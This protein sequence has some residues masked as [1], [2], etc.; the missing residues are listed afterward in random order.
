M[1]AKGRLAFTPEVASWLAGGE[2]PIVVT[3][4]GGWLG[5]AVLEMVCGALGG[6]FAGRVFAFASRR[7]EILL[8][9]GGRIV[10]APLTDLAEVEGAPLIFHCAFLTREYAGTMDQADYAAANRAIREAVVGVIERCGCV[11]IF[12]PSSGAVYEAAGDFEKNP[13]GALKLEDEAGFRG[14]A[15]SWG[16]P[17]AVLRVF[18]LSGPF[19]NKGDAYA[20]GSIIGDVLRGGPVRLRADRAVWRSYAYVGDVVGVAGAMLR[21]GGGGPVDTAGAEAIEIGDLAR[22]VA[23]LMGCGGMAVLRPDWRGAEN[24]YLGDGAEFFA[25]A[26]EAG[27]GLMGLDEQIL[28]TVG[29]LKVSK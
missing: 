25:A 10:A 27:V 14:L 2:F 29:Y 23:G 12:V 5:Q 20:L 26:R 13:Y 6:R 9:S 18:N 4:V 21:Q 16:F 1:A 8:R 7:R 11:G 22:R 24:R 28:A 19:I 15:D 17:C 3:G